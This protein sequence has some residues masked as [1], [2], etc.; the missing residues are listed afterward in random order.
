MAV[1]VYSWSQTAGSNGSASTA[2]NFA[3]NQTPASLN[4][5]ARAQMAEL[6]SWLDALGG[7]ITYGGSA[8]AYTATNA[9]PGAWSAYAAGQI[10]L[11]VPGATNTGATTLNVD[12]LGTKAVCKGASTALTAGDLVSGAPYL[13]RYDGTRFVILGST[14]VFQPLDATLTALAALSWASG[15]PLFQ[16]TAADTISLTLTPSVTSVTA[17][18]ITIASSTTPI[19]YFYENDQASNEKVWR[20]EA[21]TKTFALVTRTDADGAGVAAF[22]FARG[23]GTALGAAKHGGTSWGPTSNDGASLGTSAAAYSDAYFASGATQNY[24]NGNVIVTHSSGM[25]EVTTGAHAA[26]AVQVTGVGAET[27]AAAAHRNRMLLL[28]GDI[29]MDD[30][31]FTAGDYGMLIGDGTNRTVTRAAGCTMYVNG[32]DSATATIPAH[33]VTVFAW[34]TAA[35]VHLTGSAY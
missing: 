10:I 7:N 25:L 34:E 22:S 1:G 16:C 11:L 35:I 20:F 18:T 14:G 4:N 23:T 31:V 8:D 26:R 30:A 33:T 12:G 28:D 24:N 3:E 19:V 2:V 29:T 21:A 27:L 5:S 13:L 6:R 32:A 17:T 15:Q 9:A